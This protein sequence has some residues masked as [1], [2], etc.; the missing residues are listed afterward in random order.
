MTDAI[1]KL[2][3]AAIFDMKEGD[4]LRDDVMRG[5]VIRRQRGAAR[6]W[7]FRYRTPDG[8]RR[9]GCGAF[10][11][12]GLKEARVIAKALMVKT[13]NGGDPV[14]AAKLTKVKLPTVADLATMFNA[15]PARKDRKA[16][17]LVN[18]ELNTRLSI[19]PCLGDVPVANI[20]IG[21]IEKLKAW[22]ED[23]PRRREAERKE[24]HEFC[25]MPFTARMV[26]PGPARVSGNQALLLF[27]QM[28]KYAERDDVRM[29]PRGTNPTSDVRKNP[30]MARERKAELPELGRIFDAMN[31]VAKEWP[32]HIAALKVVLLAGTRINEL[33]TA[34]RSQINN[35][36]LTL[37]IHK[38][39]RKAEV[40]RI[41]LPPQ[42]LDIIN[43]T[44]DDGTGLLFGP[45]TVDATAY[46]WEQVRERAGC[47]D[48]Q[49]RDLRRTFASFA[50]SGGA[51]LDIIGKLFSH[52][53]TSTTAGYA[54]LQGETAEGVTHATANALLAHDRTK[55]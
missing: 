53:S 26:R 7:S 36:V 22:A 25:G 37:Q 34:K 21:H 33:I 13:L 5:L 52:A 31:E 47:P 14:A 45:M 19:I 50:L 17:T 35:G 55:T 18:D 42:A 41:V 49:Q 27:G 40:R 12:I 30:I 43:A 11:A 32:R 29:R 28:L 23:G 10:P 48:L 16:G 39:D 3:H 4:T 38:G 20:N 1:P 9:A 8:E 46:R 44:P 2:T 15:S 54:Y 51:S 24:Y 6:V